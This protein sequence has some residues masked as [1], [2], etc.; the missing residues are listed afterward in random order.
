MKPHTQINLTHTP[1]G[2]LC[3][4]LLG[5]LVF[6]GIGGLYIT[7]FFSSAVRRAVHIA[8]WCIWQFVWLD[9]ILMA[10]F[11]LCGYVAIK[12]ADRIVQVL[13]DRLFD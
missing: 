2:T 12:T 9:V 1:T 6:S 3:L 8:S 4:Y 7:T 10:V 13:L 11:W 5:L